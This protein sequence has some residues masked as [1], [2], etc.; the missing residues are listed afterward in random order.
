MFYL[1]LLEWETI[2]LSFEF[3]INKWFNFVH[4]SCSD[5]NIGFLL[6]S[7]QKTVSTLIK[8]QLTIYTF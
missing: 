1:L 2:D 6:L 4:I 3:V 8:I 5:N 7:I